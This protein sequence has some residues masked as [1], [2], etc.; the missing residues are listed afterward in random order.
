MRRLFEPIPRDRV[1]RRWT[2]LLVGVAM[3]GATAGMLVLGGLGLDPWD[4]L[5]QGLSRT[6]GLGIGTWAIIVSLIVLS[7][8]TLLR[9]RP[10]VGTLVNAVGVGL[11]IDLLVSEFH[12]PHA[13]WARIVLLVGGVVG[14]GIATGLYIGAGLG[15]GARDGLTTGIASRGHSIRVVRTS[16]EATVLLT[17]FLLGGTVGVGTVAYALAIGPITH[18][19]IPALAID[20]GLARLVSKHPPIAQPDAQLT[21]GS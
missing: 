12:Q 8:W 13:L 17:G 7:G 21:T 14:N 18:F 6:I 19:T 9:Q 16:I 15:P 2:Q 10:G 1:V 11:V 4:V 20:D 5:H 3:Y